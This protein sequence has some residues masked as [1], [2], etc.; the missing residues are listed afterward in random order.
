MLSTN[1]REFETNLRIS[2]QYCD[3]GTLVE[4]NDLRF[5]PVELAGQ[6][7]LLEMINVSDTPESPTWIAYFDGRL[8][9]HS[10]VGAKE[11]AERLIFLQSDVIITPSS[12]KSTQMVLVAQQL[13]T[14]ILQKPVDRI[15][16]QKGD[17]GSTEMKKK[18]A[19]LSKKF[20]PIT[21][22]IDQ[23]MI[24]SQDNLDALQEHIQQGHRIVIVDDVYS[25]GE[26]IRTI[27]YLLKKVYRALGKQ[28]GFKKPPIITVMREC[29]RN[30]YGELEM[31]EVPGFYTAIITPVIIGDLKQNE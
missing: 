16:F 28:D 4:Q 12:E 14:D 1:I 22:K 20:K 9:E 21:K 24:V 15:I 30:Q 26:T 11:I 18:E 10:E 3:V 25:T 23:I 13:A 19:V 5:L 27:Q 6:T 2:E 8:S 7:V 31:T 29:E 17:F